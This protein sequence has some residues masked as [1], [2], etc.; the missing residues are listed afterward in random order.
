MMEGGPGTV[1]GGGVNNPR[2]Q[3]FHSLY[4][5]HD[6]WQ[7]PTSEL[8]DPSGTCSDVGGQ[9]AVEVT[10]CSC[11]AA[12]RYQKKTNTTYVHVCARACKAVSVPLAQ[13]YE[14]TTAANNY[15]K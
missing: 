7:L 4:V 15:L 11:C 2:L 14:G 10:R 9:L 6:Q 13:R 1:I 8:K 3:F 5:M 12:N